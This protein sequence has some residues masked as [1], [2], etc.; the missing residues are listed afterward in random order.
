MAA[1]TRMEAPVSKLAPKL[2][3]ADD[4]Y[5]RDFYAWTQAQ[6]LSLARQ[7]EA[8]LDVANLLEEVE[9]LGRSQR[10]AITSRLEVLI[11]HLLKFRVQPERATPSWRRTLREQ[12]RQIERLIARNPSLRGLPREALPDIYRDAVR[13][14]SG[15]TRIPEAGFPA[16]CPFTI[17]DILDPGFEP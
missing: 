4:L 3:A 16:D 17:E 14:A 9:S 12:R 8:A 7:D 5:E 1:H 13:L 11:A 2:S 6:A 15:E 10:N